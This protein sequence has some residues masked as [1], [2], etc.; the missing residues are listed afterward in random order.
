M[1]EL[2]PITTNALDIGTLP[3]QLDPLVNDGVIINVVFRGPI[4][5]A[6][7]EY[8]DDTDGLPGA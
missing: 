7:I 6:K 1:L 3:V 8:E 5:S 2:T 4:L